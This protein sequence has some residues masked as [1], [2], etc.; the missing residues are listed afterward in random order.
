MDT[1][2]KGVDLTEPIDVSFEKNSFYI[3]DGHHRYYAAKI[4]N[5]NFIRTHEKRKTF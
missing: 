5:K 4:L 3:E 2:A 1:W